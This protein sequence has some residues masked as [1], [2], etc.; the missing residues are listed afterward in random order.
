[1]IYPWKHFSAWWVS[2]ISL[3][4]NG[5]QH[6]LLAGS[7]KKLR[8]YS[9]TFVCSGSPV[10]WHHH[11]ALL[12]GDKLDSFQRKLNQRL[13]SSWA[14][15]FSAPKAGC[16]GWTQWLALHTALNHETC[17]AVQSRALPEV[18]LAARPLLLSIDLFCCGELFIHIN[19]V[20]VRHL[21][22]WRGFNVIHF[23]HHKFMLL[24]QASL[25][26]VLLY[27]PGQTLNYL[28]F[29]TEMEYGISYIWGMRWGSLGAASLPPWAIKSRKLRTLYYLSKF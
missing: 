11:K 29:K 16:Q 13:C 20:S 5:Q 15:I 23:R 9:S 3:R 26:P 7:N 8:L 4:F 28:N 27:S 24:I 19:L 18:S 21:C 1:M 10:C 25:S 2:L 6:S 22:F 17:R 12:G 14:L